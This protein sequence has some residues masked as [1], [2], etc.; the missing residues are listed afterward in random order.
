MVG[1][2][3]RLLRRERKL[4][5]KDLAARC[6]LV[7]FRIE[8][9]TISKIERQIRSVSDL[10]MALLADALRVPIGKLVP[11]S[12]PTWQKNTQ[13]PHVQDDED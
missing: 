12:K 2:Q 4:S 7:G 13:L 10:E 5:Q 3:V 9:D 6:T 8:W 11:E 1:T